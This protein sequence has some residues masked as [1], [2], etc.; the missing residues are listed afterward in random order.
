MC[1][2]QKVYP[3]D[4]V[5][6][7]QVI[8]LHR[9]QTQCPMLLMGTVLGA[10]LPVVLYLVLPVPCAVCP[11]APLTSIRFLIVVR[12]SLNVRGSESEVGASSF[13]VCRLTSCMS[14]FE[15]KFILGLVMCLEGHQIL[16][17]R[18]QNYFCSVALYILYEDEV[19]PKG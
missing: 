8:A 4:M 9:T 5:S 13:D 17:L 3:K 12:L 15:W 1:R 11:V 18:T 6:V 7:W 16:R 2:F 10:Q 14:D 19:A